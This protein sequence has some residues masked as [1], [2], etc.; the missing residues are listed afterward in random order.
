M[1]PQA[2]RNIMLELMDCLGELASGVH[3]GK[4]KWKAL[5][6]TSKDTEGVAG[7]FVFA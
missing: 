5:V 4:C 6:V 7:T 3:S 2:R 1:H